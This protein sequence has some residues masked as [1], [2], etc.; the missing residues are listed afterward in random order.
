M[1]DAL[2]PHELCDRILGSVTH[3]ITALMP[4]L[5]EGDMES[6]ALL[7]I[8]LVGI[9]SGWA[10]H[11][12]HECLRMLGGVPYSHSAG[13]RSRH[14]GLGLTATRG[15]PPPGL[16]PPPAATLPR[17]TP[18]RA[19]RSDPATKPLSPRGRPQES[20]NLLEVHRRATKIM[21]QDWPTLRRAWPR[22]CW[23]ARGSGQPPGG[24]EINSTG[25][26]PVV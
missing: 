14:A 3:A 10:G 18:R 12:G 7:S 1:G 13:R 2:S 25:R 19:T 26:K 15:F 8:R 5:P 6:N 23:S 11:P 9:P 22:G 4:R 17:E 16:F 20:E 24:R 21:Q